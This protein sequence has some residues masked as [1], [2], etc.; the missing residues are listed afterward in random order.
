[1]AL[2]ILSSCTSAK[3]MYEKDVGNR[4]ES[5]DIA[6][7]TITN[8]DLDKLPMPVAK[9][10]EH[11]GWVGKNIPRNFFFRFDGKFSLKPGKEMKVKSEQYNWLK[12]APARLF[13]MRN[14]MISGYHRYNDKG[15]SMLIKLFGRIKVA[16]EDGPKMDQAE[17]VTYLNDMCLFA[18]GALVEAPILWETV[19][20]KTVKATISQYNNTISATLYFNEKYELVNFVSNDRFAT[21]GNGKPENIPWS[22]P[23]KD[24]A[25]INGIKL[26]SYGEAIWHYPDHD[27]SYA[28]LNI[29]NVRWNVHE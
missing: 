22:T 27:F 4:L 8:S 18:P 5:Q 25:E 12:Q 19:R 9:Y 15:A 17:L 2:S 24:Y 13:Y 3:K 23:V 20:P 1:M 26:P 7:R 14:P 6:T 10:L 16:Y 21:T 11:C 29:K 28:K